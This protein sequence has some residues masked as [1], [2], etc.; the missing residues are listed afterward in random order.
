GNTWYE[1]AVAPVIPD[2]G[3]PDRVHQVIGLL[4]DGTA[5]HRLQHRIES[6]DAAGEELLRIDPET[7]ANMNMAERLSLL[8]RR[9]LHVMHEVLH[10]ETFEVRLL[11]Q[12]TGKLEL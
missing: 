3:A 6:V 5:A 8:E 11:D 12:R 1:Q 7:I 2:P 9:I 10:Y 4:W